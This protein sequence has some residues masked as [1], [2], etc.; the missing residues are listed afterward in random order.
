MWPNRGSRQPGSSTSPGQPDAKPDQPET[1]PDQP[2]TKPDQAETRPDQPADK[3]AAQGPPVPPSVTPRPP[4][5][6][7]EA[8]REPGRGVKI[9]RA[10][11][12][13]IAVAALAGAVYAITEIEST[14]DENRED[15]QAVSALRADLEALREELTERLDTLERRV[16]DA[17]DA[18]TQRRLAQDLDALDRRVGRLDRQDD[19]GESDEIA[20]RVDDLERR[21]ENLANDQN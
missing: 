19:G 10:V 12:T 2:E 8:E 20:R 5:E 14:K 16:D 13:L 4:G 1:K 7:P 3:P 11:V 9:W 21:I 18:R 6:G 17:A 15:D